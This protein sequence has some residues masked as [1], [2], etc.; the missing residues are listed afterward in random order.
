MQSQMFFR[1]S[2]LFGLGCERTKIFRS[3]DQL[4]VLFEVAEIDQIFMILYSKSSRSHQFQ[5]F[6]K[7]SSLFHQVAETKKADERCDIVQY[8]IAQTTLEQVFQKLV[9]QPNRIKLKQILGSFFF[10]W[11]FQKFGQTSY[12]NFVFCAPQSRFSILNLSFD[13]V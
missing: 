13:F 12:T 5:Y 4:A 2:L 8:S 6:S 7:F 1:Q 9:K 11:K 10:F 3:A